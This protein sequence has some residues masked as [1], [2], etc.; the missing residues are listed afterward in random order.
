MTRLLVALLFVPGAAR[1]ADRVDY[2]RDV[3]PILA[4]K[5]VAC[6]GA[7]KQKGGL[8]LETVR[9]IRMGGRSGPVV[10]PGRPADSRLIDR[11]TG[12]GGETPM[13]PPGDGERLT[14]AQ[15]GT[16]TRWIEQGA[17]G[18]DEPDPPD[19]R[20]HWAFRPPV[21][22]PIPILSTQYSVLSNP[23]D[24]FLAAEWQRHGLTPVPPADRATLLRRVTIDLTGLPPT[25]AEL[26]AFLADPSPGAYEKVVD[27][28][29]ASPRYGE[30]WARHWMD[31]W[32]YADWSGE[33][34]NQVRG[35]PKHVWRWRDWI[36]D[37]L[38]ADAGYD[39]MVTEM[40][41]G[42]E[43]APA[44]PRVL[45]ATGFLARN[46]Y[47]FNRNVWLDDTVEH[48]AKAFLGL[49]V[50]CARCHDHKFD[51]IAQT[52]YYRLRA[53]FE[54]HNVRTDP[55][56]GQP[57]VQ[58]DGLVRVYDHDPAAPT[59]LFRRGD[60][61]RPDRDHPLTPGV[62]E[63]FAVQLAPEP[64]RVGPPADA[65]TAAAGHGAAGLPPELS[66]GRRLAL[67]RWL[68]A[69]TNPLTARVAVNHVWLRHFGSPLVDDVTD[70]GLRAARPRHAALLDWLAVE[71]TEP[72]GRA[73]G[74]EAPGAPW[75]MKPLHR[76]IVTSTA[77]RMRSDAETG[78]AA[79]DPENRFLWRMS[80]RRLEAEAVRDCVLATAGN[81]DLTAG[82]PEIPLTEAE[83]AR[84][85]ALY[86]R[87]AHER[88]V[89]FLTAFDSPNPLECYRRAVTVTPQQALA[90]L[91]SPLVLEQARLLAR[92][93]AAGTD[94][95][96]DPDAA[97]VATA[98]E[99]VLFRP[100]TAAEADRC[101]VFLAVQ[102]ARL[103][104]PGKLTPA[105][106]GPSCRVPPSADPRLRAR[107]NLVH[108]LFNH[109]DFV[110]VR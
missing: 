59:Y 39:R 83:T 76:L 12:A 52:D 91:N 8:R 34:N 32:R 61:T 90:G 36:V 58:K 69:P 56:P 3:R 22:P 2:A 47:K 53:V 38:N 104:N 77:Y 79:A 109:T 54:P 16:L 41:A 55:V 100:P 67:A 68:T 66:T 19:P 107:E 95:E 25:P 57:D 9:L 27:R 5:C 101:R 85:R 49:T 103:A 35:S 96:K 93:L 24:K 29:L 99:R 87:H 10:V 73:G 94:N 65:G 106:G 60:E 108:V 23:V 11:V 31:V 98:F 92:E 18:P 13:P 37:S 64:V 26:R 80:P 40:L 102:A 20:Q 86:F 30:R 88:Q 84:R 89:P 82:G 81:L 50:A 70:F 78:P 44:D 74:R 21:R 97:F 46:Y 6:H 42:D 62:P 28:L 7:W 45:R 75:S 48:T 4:E 63:V 14:A 72:S 110:T 105:E 43:V 33:N 17:D 15:L 1:D 51:P 71:L